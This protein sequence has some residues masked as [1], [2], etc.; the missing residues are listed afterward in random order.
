MADTV[1]SQSQT[2]TGK[3]MD[4]V[5]SK[6]ADVTIYSTGAPAGEADFAKAM[7]VY[8]KSGTA[9]QGYLVLQPG[10]INDLRQMFEQGNKYVQQKAQDIASSPD[11]GSTPTVENL[12]LGGSAIGGLVNAAKRTAPLLADQIS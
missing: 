12:G 9:P 2:P 3:M 10:K 11:I 8:N 6:G 7:D 4:A 1:Q 5:D